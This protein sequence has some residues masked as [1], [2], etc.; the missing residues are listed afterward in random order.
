VVSTVLLMQVHSLLGLVIVF[1]GL[2]AGQG[3][4]GNSS[5]I[6]I[7]EFGRRE[8]LPMRIAVMNGLSSLM[9]TIGLVGGGLIARSLSLETLFWFAILAKMSAVAI[10]IRWVDEPRRRRRPY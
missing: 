3:G 10:I 8:D 7:L 1:A 9:N 4:Y 5:Q 2:G 6:I